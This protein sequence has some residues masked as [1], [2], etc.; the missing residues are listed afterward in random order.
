VKWANGIRVGAR[1]WC[2]IELSLR[3]P[4]YIDSYLKLIWYE[5]ARNRLAASWWPLSIQVS[6]PYCPFAFKK[7]QINIDL[8]HSHP[9]VQDTLNIGFIIHVILE[10]PASFCIWES[11]LLEFYSIDHRSTSK[12]TL[13]FQ[14]DMTGLQ[15]RFLS[16]WFT[17]RI[18]LFVKTE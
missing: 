17:H 6:L 13:P 12:W 15:Q 4:V 1:M 2:A 7:M 5:S 16:L 3:L 9:Y 11:V 8:F 18:P 14:D 10:V